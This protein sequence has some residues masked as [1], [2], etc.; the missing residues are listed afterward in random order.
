[1]ERMGLN[2]LY[3]VLGE[4]SRLGYTFKCRDLGLQCDYQAT[5]DN[6]ADL[7]KQATS[8]AMQ[9]HKAEAMTLASKIRDAIKKT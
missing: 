2:V 1:M 8:H 7:A 4:V 9:A 3:L 5:A 6:A